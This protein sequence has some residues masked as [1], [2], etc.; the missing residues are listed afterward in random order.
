MGWTNS[1]LYQFEVDGRRFTDL[2]TWEPFDDPEEPVD[3]EIMTLAE[4]DLKEG[5]RFTYLYDFGDYWLHGVVV[6]EAMPIPR[7]CDSRAALRARARALLK[8]AEA[9]LAISAFSK[10]STIPHTRSIIAAAAGSVAPST[11]SHSMPPEPIVA[12]EADW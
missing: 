7:E 5:C 9:R 3:A 11:P 6:E 12:A 1:H 2:E 10:H 4:L 8:I